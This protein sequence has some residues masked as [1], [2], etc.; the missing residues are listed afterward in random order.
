MKKSEL[1]QKLIDIEKLTN[2]ETKITKGYIPYLEEQKDLV[3]KG[4]VELE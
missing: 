4:D 2:K 1:I 3:I